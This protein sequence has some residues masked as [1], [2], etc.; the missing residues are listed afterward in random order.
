VIGARASQRCELC[1]RQ[2]RHGQGA[3]EHLPEERVAH[4]QSA[5]FNAQK[6]SVIGADN[7]CWKYLHCAIIKHREAERD[8]EFIGEDKDRQL[9]LVWRETKIGNV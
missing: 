9:E 3:V 1:R 2:R 6:K 4:I 7:R 5:G 8:F